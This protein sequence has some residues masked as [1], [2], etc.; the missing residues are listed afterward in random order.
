MYFA[1]LN[2]SNFLVYTSHIL[3]SNRNFMKGAV[4]LGLF[5]RTWRNFRQLLANIYLFKVDNR[6]SRKRFEICW[7]LTKKKQQ[8]H[9]K[10][11]I[12]VES[13]FPQNI[14]QRKIKKVFYMKLFLT[15]D[16]LSHVCKCWK[17]AKH[18]LT[19]S[20]MGFFGFA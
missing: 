11:V 4:H 19:L 14:S 20:T 3:L 13:F 5:L 12:D 7:K 1:Y 16:H 6:N 9:R 17:I 2:L 18:T 15:K 10:N 8:Q